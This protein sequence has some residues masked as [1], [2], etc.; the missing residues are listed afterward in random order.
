MTKIADK[1]QLTLDGFPSTAKCKKKACPKTIQNQSLH[2]YIVK[3]FVERIL[4]ENEEA[5]RGFLQDM[6]RL[7]TE[8]FSLTEEQAKD[9]VRDMLDITLYN[10]FCR[11]P[12]FAHY[13]DGWRISWIS[14]MLHNSRF[15][16]F[17]MNETVCRCR[18]R[19]RKESEERQQQQLAEHDFIVTQNHP[20]SPYEYCDPDTGVRY[21]DDAIEGRIQLPPDAPPRPTND[22]WW[23]VI[24]CEWVKG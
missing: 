18:K 21:Y 11:Q 10:Y 20:L 13:T 8:H 5:N 22:A 9:C 15:G 7:F 3:S 16:R 17:M 23:N 1:Q 19:W 2:N 14:N 12:R 24:R 4:D 6:N